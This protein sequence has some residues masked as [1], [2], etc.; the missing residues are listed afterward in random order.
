MRTVGKKVMY[1]TARPSARYEFCL[2]VNG[3]SYVHV[4]CVACFI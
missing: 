1:E 3:T 2:I 4:C